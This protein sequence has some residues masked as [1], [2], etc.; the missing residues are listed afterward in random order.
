MIRFLVGGIFAVALILYLAW[1]GGQAAMMM[2]RM[3]HGL[4]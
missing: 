2:M 3:A 1:L 4:M